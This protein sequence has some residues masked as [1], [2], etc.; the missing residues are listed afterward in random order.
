M[1]KE[2]RCRNSQKDDSIHGNLP[3]IDSRRSPATAAG[4]CATGPD[5]AIAAIGSGERDAAAA[6]SCIATITPLSR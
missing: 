3:S 6:P 5:I 4:D 1:L 2:H